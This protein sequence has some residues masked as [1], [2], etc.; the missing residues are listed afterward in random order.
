M[1]LV[2]VSRERGELSHQLTVLARQKEA[3]TEELGRVRQRLEQSNETN[4][5]LN[6]SLE[7]LVKDCEEKQVSIKFFC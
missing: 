4:S 7:D 2:Q 1:E 3:V 5:R 6:R